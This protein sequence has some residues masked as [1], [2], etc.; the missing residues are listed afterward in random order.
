MI[1]GKGNVAIGLGPPSSRPWLRDYLRGVQS[2]P[3]RERQPFF[4][5]RLRPWHIGSEMCA[6]TFPTLQRGYHDHQ[7]DQGRIGFRGWLQ[8][9]CAVKR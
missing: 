7:G 8:Y 3:K 4:V 1:W 5:A 9:S 6:A 2:R